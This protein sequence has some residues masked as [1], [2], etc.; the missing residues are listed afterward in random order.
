MVLQ[1]RTVQ[2]SIFHPDSADVGPS[3]NVVRFLLL[4]LQ[5]ANRVNYMFEQGVASFW[6]HCTISVYSNAVSRVTLLRQLSAHDTDIQAFHEH[7]RH[8]MPAY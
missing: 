6:V 3:M 8:F 1:R 4:F 5:L 2:R 7:L